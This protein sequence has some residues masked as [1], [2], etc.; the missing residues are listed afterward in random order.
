MTEFI[1]LVKNDKD[2][3]SR[4]SLNNIL[5]RNDC[6]IKV[7][8]DNCIHCIN[9]KP[10]WDKYVE[11]MINTKTKKAYIIEIES[12]CFDTVEN[13]V[14]KQ[15]V[16]GFPTI[17]Y[18]KNNKAQLYDGERENSKMF[19][20]SMS[21]IKDSLDLYKNRMNKINKIEKSNKKL[22]KKTSNKKSKKSKKSK[23][24]KKVKFNLRKNKTKKIGSRKK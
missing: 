3:I 2:C 20:W 5:T 9:M 7:Y 13:P 18:L 14:V 23:Q 15:N 1:K 8:S 19:D 16:M 22:S 10:E 6:I 4:D 11:R 17:M 12:S 21:K 24:N